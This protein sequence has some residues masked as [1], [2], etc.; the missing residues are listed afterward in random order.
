MENA[1]ATTGL[2]Q[3]TLPRIHPKEEKSVIVKFT[4]QTEAQVIKGQ[5]KKDIAQRIQAAAGGAQANH[6]VLAVRQ[7]KSGDLAVHMDSAAGKKEME[8]KKEWIK[9]IAP[10]AVT[11]KKT[12]PIMVHGVRIA[13]LPLDAWEKQVKRL[14]KENVK[15]HPSLQIRGLR[16]L[17][18]TD[19]KEFSILI[20][21]TD[22]AEQANRMIR[23]DVIISYDL[24]FAEKYDF[25]CRIAQYFK[26][27][28]YG[29]ISTIYL[30]T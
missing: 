18:R 19:E 24:K 3:D 21:E 15:L 17:G 1:R 2:A 9:A 29:Y 22:S 25:K 5:S 8:E 26:Y 20:I 14:I 12:W 30:N 11:R 7:F 28:K 6:T 10:S 4:D 27:Q 16:W 13:D 23:K